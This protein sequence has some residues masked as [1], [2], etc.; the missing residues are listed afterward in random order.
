MKAKGSWI[1]L[2][3]ESPLIITLIPPLMSKPEGGKEI[4]GLEMG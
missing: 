1:E 2:L 4:G 3:G